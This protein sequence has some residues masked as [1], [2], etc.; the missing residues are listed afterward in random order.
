M[1][2]D[3]TSKKNKIVHKEIELIQIKVV[4]LNNANILVGL[5]Q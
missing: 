3:S 1:M 5:G 2:S 4:E